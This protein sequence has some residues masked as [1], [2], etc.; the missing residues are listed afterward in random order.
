MYGLVLETEHCPDGVDLDEKGVFRPRTKRRFPLKL[1]TH[2]L[3]NPFVLRFI[4]AGDDEALAQFFTKFGFPESGVA[5][6]S[7]KDAQSIQEVMTT[8][9]TKAG[10]EQAQQ[11]ALFLTKQL[12]LS[13]I[14]DTGVLPEMEGRR[15]LFKVLSLGALMRMECAM[16]AEKDARLSACEHCDT[17]FLT[18]PTTGRR[19][20]AIYCSDRCR[21]A[22]L[23]ARKAS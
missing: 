5:E 13:R 12:S 23:R 17:Q 9:L 6:C 15:L 11:E 21:L 7:R 3:G 19:G 1:E 10:S 4:N 8:L 22:A 14:G 18:G 16:V 2:D 20:H